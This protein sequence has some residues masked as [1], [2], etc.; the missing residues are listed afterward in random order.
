MTKR[1]VTGISLLILFTTFISQKEIV[2]KK[3][4][5]QK[6]QIKN[7]SLLAAE[8][9]KKELASIY[10]KNLIFLNIN[11]VEKILKKNTFIESFYTKK[12]YPNT[13]IINIYEKNPI[14][15]M[16]NKKEKT[17]LSEKIEPVKFKD[18]KKYKDLPIIFGNEKNFKDFYY[19][20]KE[21]NFPLN[22]IKKYYYFES[23]R[24]DLITID[25]K[26]I[27]LPS[28]NYIKSLNNFLDIKN[29]GDFNKYKVFD[30]RINNQLILK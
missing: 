1:F 21:I 4:N 15:V 10:N 2:I 22:T 6:I 17:Y 29:R 26:I 7:N 14:A 25:N 27:K 9:I 24:W 12:I 11:E 28:K 8:E 16:Q 20:L 3:F 23:N 19:D 30:Y 13:L 18:L 5:I